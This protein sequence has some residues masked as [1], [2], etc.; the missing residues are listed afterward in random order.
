M[1]SLPEAQVCSPCILALG[2][3]LQATSFSNYDDTVASEWAS[4]QKTCNVNYPTDVQPPE[5]TPTDVTGFAPA[6]FTISTACISGNTYDVV[7]GDD[8][9]RI[10]TSKSVSTGGLI[11]LNQ[12]FPDCSNLLG[13][14]SAGMTFVSSEVLYGRLRTDINLPAGQSLC[15]P[16]SCTIYTI[17]SNDTCY[18]IANN[19]NITYTQ[20]LSWNP[21]INGYCSNL[22]TGQNICVG[23]PGTVWT[24]TTIAGATATKTDVC[25]S[26]TIAPPGPTAHG[27]S[28]L[29]QM[30][31]TLTSMLKIFRHDF[32]L[33]QILRRQERRRLSSYR[34]QLY[35][36]AQPLP[37]HQSRRKQWLHEP[38]ARPILLRRTDS[39]LEL[40]KHKRKF[41]LNLRH[42]SRP[43]TH[44]QVL[45]QLPAW[46]VLTRA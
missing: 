35:N 42:C 40:H 27:E 43:H 28:P 37:S 26:A 2:Q 16:Q 6:N 39:G 9:V 18:G 24:G 44:R 5:A 38:G 19:A 3:L 31:P 4:I 8:C 11:V 36:Y 7:S 23:Q 17:Q 20:L 33:R 15:L 22:L 41:F 32:R 10:S 25:A 12:L 21:T 29:A 13:M 30:P 1:A 14:W 34:P 45:H 46:R